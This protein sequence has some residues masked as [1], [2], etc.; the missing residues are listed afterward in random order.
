MSIPD[1]TYNSVGEV[2]LHVRCGDVNT[3]MRFSPEVAKQVAAAIVVK[4][5]K[6][7]QLRDLQQRDASG[8]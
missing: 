1:V 3:T 2:L 6:A 8:R 7:Q 5:D 4:S